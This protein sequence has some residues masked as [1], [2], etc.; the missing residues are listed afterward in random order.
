MSNIKKKNLF[1]HETSDLNNINHSPKNNIRFDN[2]R[3]TSK[4]SG[5]RE[6]RRVEQQFDSTNHFTSLKK[7]VIQIHNLFYL[8]LSDLSTYNSHRTDR[9]GTFGLA[10]SYLTG[11]L[12]RNLNGYNA[13]AQLGI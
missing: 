5:K 10:P 9:D 7:L 2:I 12:E 6:F 4:I 1:S 3:P 11:S 13:G 8:S